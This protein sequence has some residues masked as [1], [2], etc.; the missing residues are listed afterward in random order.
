MAKIIKLIFTEE[1]VGLGREEDDPV[2][3]KQQLFT[4]DGELV[5][6]HDSVTNYGYFNPSVIKETNT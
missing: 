4:L 6:E 5:A 1:R 2:R 3:L